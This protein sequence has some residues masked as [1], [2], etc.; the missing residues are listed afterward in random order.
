MSKAK[1]IVIGNGIVGHHFLEHLVEI[2]LAKDF[3]VTVIG[4]EK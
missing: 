3:A 2:G 1:L 4:E